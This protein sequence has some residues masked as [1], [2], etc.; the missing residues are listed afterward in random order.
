[1]IK[2]TID[3]VVNDLKSKRDALQLAHQQLKNDS[4]DWNKGIILLSLA[5]GGLESIKMKLKLDG[6]IWA[7][8]PIILSSITA[9]CSA[10]IKFRNFP[11]RMETIINA[12]GLITNILGKA[13]N[14]NNID[15]ELLHEYNDALTYLETSLYPDQ[16]KVFLKQSHSNLIKIM[17]QEQKYYDLIVKVNN[18]EKINLSDDS[19]NSDDSVDKIKEDFKEDYKDELDITEHTRRHLPPIMETTDEPP[20]KEIDAL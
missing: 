7:L 5:T 11:Q 6:P 13:R 9:A 14:R 1:M 18:H 4:D 3:E 10:L 2:D 15:D 20:S 8:M 16:R 12:S 17:E 19:S